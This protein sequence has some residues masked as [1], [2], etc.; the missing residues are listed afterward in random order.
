ML[1]STQLEL[2]W[3]RIVKLCLGAGV[4]LG[5]MEGCSDESTRPP[6]QQP[7]RIAAEM[8]RQ[9]WRDQLQPRSGTAKLNDVV[10]SD[11]LLAKLTTCKR[12]FN[13][14]NDIQ[15]CLRPSERKTAFL[16]GNMDALDREGNCW[17]V[18]IRSSQSACDGGE[19]TGYLDLKG[20][21]LLIWEPP[22]G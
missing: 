12:C 13:D 15:N 6:S 14:I 9:M 11:N 5:L 4:A 7:A 22:E 10:E 19:I 8:I 17:E 18:T 20:N 21:L 2:S 16:F 3:N 1:R